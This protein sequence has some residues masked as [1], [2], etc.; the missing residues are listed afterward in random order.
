VLPKGPVVR[1]CWCVVRVNPGSSPVLTM[2]EYEIGFLDMLR[3]VD[4]IK[5]EKIKI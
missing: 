5:D 4:S 1:V 2:A 3:Y